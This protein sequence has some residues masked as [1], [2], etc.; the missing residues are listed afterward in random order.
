MNEKEQSRIN[1]ILVTSGRNE[2]PA[3]ARHLVEKRVAA[4]VNIAEIRSCYRWE[5][6]F[7][8]DPEVLLIIKTAREKVEEALAAI[9]EVHPYTLPEM[10]VLP[11]VAGY[12]PY[13]AWV[14]EETTR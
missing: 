4:C 7:C 9:R 13:L 11:V 1:V 2:G 5:G 12:P 8:D 10:I 6:R 14:E 3:I